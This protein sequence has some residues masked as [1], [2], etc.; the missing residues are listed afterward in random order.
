MW[1]GRSPMENKPFYFCHVFPHGFPETTC[2]PVMLSKSPPPTAK[3]LVWS[4]GP[5]WPKVYDSA[6]DWRTLIPYVFPAPIGSF[7]PL[8]GGVVRAVSSLLFTERVIVALSERLGCFQTSR[9]SHPD[10]LGP[11]ATLALSLCTPPAWYGPHRQSGAR[12]E[13]RRVLPLALSCLLPF[14]GTRG[15]ARAASF[16]CWGNYPP[17]VP[18]RLVPPGR[19]RSSVGSRENKNNRRRRGG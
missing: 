4:L 19:S 2:F 15:T 16:P 14:L 8:L 6:R 12:T 9:F 13:A 7:S 18:R 1:L 3:L 10:Q 17:S 11:C 5:D